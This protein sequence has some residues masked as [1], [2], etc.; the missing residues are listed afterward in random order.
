MKYNEITEVEESLITMVM[1][2]NQE[3]I[4]KSILQYNFLL[5]HTCQYKFLSWL[6]V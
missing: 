4:N 1:A 6:L 3:C 2:H 5:D